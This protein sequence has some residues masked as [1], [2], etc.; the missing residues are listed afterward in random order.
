M[1]ETLQLLH[2][3]LGIPGSGR[4]RYGAAMELFRQGV[5][6]EAQLDLYREASPFDAR[7]PATLLQER[8]LP[9]VLPLPGSAA[10][11]L[12]RLLAA[13]GDYLADLTHP[14]HEDVRRGLARCGPEAGHSPAKQHPVVERWLETA[15]RHAAEHAPHLADAIAAA[16]P[17]LAWISYDRYPR[18]EI[19]ESFA[20]G[21]AFAA[22]AGG[23]APFPAADF[24]L[25]LFLIAPHVLYRDHCHRAPELYAPLTGPHGWRF[26]PERPLIVKPA[27]EP[28]WNP[29]LQPHLTKVGAVPF[30]CLF[31][32]TRDVAE[33]ARVMP[34]GDWAEIE[35][36]ELAAAQRAS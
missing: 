15:L 12:R 28:V 20:E 34:A 26:A 10:S 31:V 17:H 4:V 18:H 33:A 1:D 11:V 21:H 2:T 3:P 9:P 13:A 7:D 14:G 24:E 29:S 19:G 16:A 23:D 30:L 22:I 32:W 27:G 25:G 5:L 36:A 6:S 8:G 35:A